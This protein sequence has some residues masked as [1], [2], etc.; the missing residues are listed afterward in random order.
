MASKAG[1]RTSEAGSIPQAEERL[2]IE[3][4]IRSNSALS[5]CLKTLLKGIQVSI[6][7][8]ILFLQVGTVLPMDF[9]YSFGGVMNFAVR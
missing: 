7:R 9:E 1:S 5:E 8:S 4:N 2:L 3:F 6:L